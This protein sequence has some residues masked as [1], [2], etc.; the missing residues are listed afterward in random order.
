MQSLEIISI[1]LWQILISLCNLLILFFVLKK[2][3]YQPVMKVMADRQNKI[4]TQLANAKNAEECSQKLRAEYEEKLEQ[5]AAE[6]DAIIKGAVQRA[7]QQEEEILRNANASA[8][9]TV[10]RAEEQVELERKKALNELKDEVSGMAVDI[11]SAVLEKNLSAEDNQA[12]ID[13][14]IE[15]LGETR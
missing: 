2:F 6:S 14:F 12:L 1:N 8:Q 9:R 7:R 10:Q 5:A 15:N 13:K 3:L 11:A 4:E